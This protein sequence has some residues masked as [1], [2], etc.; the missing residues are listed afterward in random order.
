MS[1]RLTR[2]RVP[3]PYQGFFKCCSFPT[4]LFWWM[5]GKKEKRKRK[6]LLDMI[7]RP[8]FFGMRFS[9]LPDCD[10]SAI[11]RKLTSG[12]WLATLM[13]RSLPPPSRLMDFVWCGHLWTLEPICYLIGD[14]CIMPISPPNSTWPGGLG[15]AGFIFSQV[16]WG[17]EWVRPCLDLVSAKSDLSFFVLPFP[18]SFLSRY[19]S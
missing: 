12:I 17:T 2:L 4:L 6:G 7:M 3:M 14:N 5:R 11:H 10:C 1:H 19:C 9:S 16:I 15:H 8:F 18:Y 13:Q